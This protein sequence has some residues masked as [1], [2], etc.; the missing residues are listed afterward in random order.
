MSFGGAGMAQWLSIC[1]PCRPPTNVADSR[2][3]RQMWVEFL[4]CFRLPS[5]LIRSKTEVYV[6]ENGGFR[7]RSL[8]WRFLKTE[9]QRLCGRAKPEVFENGGSA[10]LCGQA[11]TEV[12]ENDYVNGIGMPQLKTQNRCFL[13]RFRWSSVDGRKRCKNASVDEKLFIRFQ[14]TENGVFRKRISVDRASV[15]LLSVTLIK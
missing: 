3:Q 1:L 4:I 9:V 11:K 6:C 14:E 10:S 12:F 8:E 2:T 5:T 15:V 13:M 7:K